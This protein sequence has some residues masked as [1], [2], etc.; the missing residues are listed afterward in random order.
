MREARRNPALRATF[1]MEQHIGHQS[2][3]QNLR[4]Y[5]DQ[6]PEVVPHWVE[7]T[8][9][10][11]GFFGKTLGF[12]PEHLQGTLV[13]MTQVFRGLAQKS[14]DI[15]VY[16][17]QVPA[18]FTLGLVGWNPIVLCMDITPRQYDTM[19]A[20]YHHRPDRNPLVRWF[21]HRV[22]Y[23]LLHKAA[24]ILPWSSWVKGSLVDDYG[25][26]P[27]KIEILPPGVDL[28]TWKPGSVPQNDRVRILFVGGDFYRKGGDL[29]LEAFRTLPPGMA[30]LVL[31]T[32]SEIPLGEGISVYNHLQPNSLELIELYQSC[33]VFVLPTKAEA[34][35]IAAVEASAA[36]LPVVATRVGGLPDIVLD[37]ESGYLVP[38]KDGRS[39]AER[40]TLLVSDSTR[41]HSFGHRSRQH[42]QSHFDARKNAE[43]MTAILLEILQNE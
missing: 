17:T 31:V 4:R 39:L 20:E 24:R 2:Y 30:E 9:K 25:I 11:S 29:L 26:D 27:T 41:R 3:Y 1:V 15:S 6:Q 34:F 14:R 16:N 35:G 36:G 22:N 43:R 12:L 8:Y 19:A 10:H 32:R 7:I 42:A 33:D 38:A 40:L 18:S 5:V 21:K 37:G 28:D 13:G 23:R